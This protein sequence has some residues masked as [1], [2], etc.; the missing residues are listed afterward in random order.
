[1]IGCLAASGSSAVRQ[2]ARIAIHIDEV[3]QI[4]ALFRRTASL[5]GSLLSAPA[6]YPTGR[7]AFARTSVREIEDI[8]D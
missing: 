3:S 8:S 2:W 5:V 6:S 4:Q 7:S 1:M